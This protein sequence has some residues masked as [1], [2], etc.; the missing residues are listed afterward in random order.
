MRASGGGGHAPGA[1]AGHRCAGKTRH[2]VHVGRHMMRRQH[3]AT[4]RSRQCKN[5]DVMHIC[6]VV[7]LAKTSTFLAYCEPCVSYFVADTCVSAGCEQETR[8]Y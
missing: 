6:A 2:T 4:S 1:V 7:M 3:T 5:G 8:L